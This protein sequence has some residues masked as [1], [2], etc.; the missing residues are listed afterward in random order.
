M[1]D[2]LNWLCDEAPEWV[3]YVALILFVFFLAFALGLL[4]VL[5][6]WAVRNGYWIVFAIPP[7]AAIWAILRAYQ[8][9][10]EDQDE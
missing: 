4:A 2:F 5:V 6:V 7:V 8:K 3:R 1:K 10:R 9:S